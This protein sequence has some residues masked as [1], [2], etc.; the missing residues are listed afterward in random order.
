MFIL[1]YF[2]ICFTLIGYGFI[3]SKVLRLNF[4]NYG[5][6]GLLGISFSTVISYSTSIFFVHNYTFNSIFLLLGILSFLLNFNKNLKYKKNILITLIVFLI[7][8][9][10]I[11][12]GKN[13]DDFGYY[14]FPY[15]Y[16][17]TQMEHPV[18]MGLLNNGF[19]NHS[20][21]F[22][23]SS[24]FYLPK[25]SFYLLH[26][27]PVYFLGFS[28]LILFNYIRNKK[29]FENLKFI[30][31]YS[32]MIIMFINIF[33]YRLAEHGTDRSGM[34]LIFILSLIALLIQ[35]IKD[36]NRN[37]N[38]FYF[39]SIISV[40]IFSLK[41]FYIIYSPLVFI[42][43]FSCFKKK[44]IEIL[45]SRSILFCSLFFF[46]VI[47]YNIINS[48]C[49]IFPLSISCFDGFLWSLSS[50]K[51]QGVNTWYELWSKAGASPNYVVDDQLEYIKGFNWLPN[52]IENYFFNK[53][54][55][56]LLSIF[57]VIMIFWMIFFLNKK[58]KDKKIISYKIIY[59]YFV[60][61]L[62]EWF[63]KHP[64]LR[65]GGYHLIPILSFILLSLSFN[66]LDVKFSE[67]LKK[68]SIIL[69]ITITVFYGRNINR[70]IKE[71]NLY[72]YNPFKSYRFIYDKKFYNRYLDVIKKNSFGYKYVDFLG[73]E[74]MVIQRIKK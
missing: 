41:P 59:L 49:L 54:S 43:L 39:I 46:F 11:F 15:S 52:W 51:I 32:L 17:M 14:H 37:K 27:T 44:L 57:F 48:G 40:L 1:Y 64:S 24:L 55:D 45:A 5:F 60:F 58:K 36:E 18:G 3:L 13:H 23:L 29:M 66:N 7:L 20:S 53:V 63:F 4:Y 26:I 16:L 21:I 12:V 9:A 38:L 73:K 61:C 70:L 62:I 35:N 47:F 31:F 2:L 69:L 34:I 8:L 74:I 56:F 67:F 71:H 33:F 68:S 25:V 22:F 28:N 10:F 19:R 42:V 50:E 6:L 65:Y 72:N 30:N